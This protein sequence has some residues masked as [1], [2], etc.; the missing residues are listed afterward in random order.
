[1]P[2]AL[3]AKHIP[4]Q[5]VEIWQQ[6]VNVISELIAV[7]SVMIN[8]LQPPELEVFRSNSS[9]DNPFPSGT[10]MQMAGVYCATAA[11]QRRKLQVE[12]ARQDP[13]WADSTTAQAGIFAYLGFPLCWPNGD[14]FGTLCAVDI[15]GNKWGQ[16]YESLLHTFK[17]AIEAHL[18]LLVTMEHLDKKNQEL[19]RAL[20]EVKTL[21]GLMPICAAC[22]NIRDD[23]GYWRKIENY[24]GRHSEVTFSHGM[25]PECIQK[26]YPDLYSR[27][28][29]PEPTADNGDDKDKSG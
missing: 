18:A 7:P 17:D 29:Y 21:R 5:I 3:A 8:R 11:A 13:E 10:R 14:V 12:D 25:C 20:G 2:E 27:E 4:Q 15:K 6:I 9:P 1:M 19:E 24:L 26:L 28:M 23:K 16:R 22:K